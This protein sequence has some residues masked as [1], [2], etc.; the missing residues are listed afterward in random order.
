VHEGLGEQLEL[1]AL[2]AL[3]EDQTEVVVKVRGLTCL[4]NQ[5]GK[6]RFATSQREVSR[7]A[8]GSVNGQTIDPVTGLAQTLHRAEHS[9]VRFEVEVLGR[10]AGAD[11]LDGRRIEQDHAQHGALGLKAMRGN[12]FRTMC[13]QLGRS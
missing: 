1:L 8:E 6:P 12:E 13:Y 4:L 2:A 9:T 11:R 3:L 5:H 10:Q 7:F